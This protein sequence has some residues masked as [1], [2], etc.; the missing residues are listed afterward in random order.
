MM[1]QREG[2]GQGPRGTQGLVFKIWPR[3]NTGQHGVH[4]NYYNRDSISLVELKS[5]NYNLYNMICITCIINT[6]L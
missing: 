2:P 5:F 6:H 3:P 1:I 4:S